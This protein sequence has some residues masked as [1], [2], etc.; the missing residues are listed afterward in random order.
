MFVGS[1]IL[2]ILLSQSSEGIHNGVDARFDF[3]TFVASLRIN[4][5]HECGGSVIDS[6]II[7]TA[8]Q[9]VK[10][11]P[12]GKI[13]V[14]VGTPDVRRGGKIIKVAAMA[15]HENYGELKNDI[16]LL[17][18]RSSVL[19]TGVT[20]VKLA[21][22]EPVE[23]E[24]PSNAGWGEK[25]LETFGSTK[26]LQNGVTKVQNRSMCS[27]ELDEQVGADLLCTFYHQ[28]DICPG[29][30]G[31]PMIFANHLVGIA[32]QGHG[33]GYVVLPSLYTNVAHF[34][35]WIDAKSEELKK[36]K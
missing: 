19:T 12:V 20:T 28:N 26:K 33:C 30:Y 24:F 11:I 21:D 25:Q 9:C 27:D 3:W 23:N 6:R 15:V 10:D 2:V 31:G 5:Y 13:A 17:W 22:K 32:V 1:C 35:K 18:T 4:G 36:N 14:R 16:A 29:D 7:L 8:A 34:R